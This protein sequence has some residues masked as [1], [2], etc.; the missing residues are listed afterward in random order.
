[1]PASTIR[2]CGSSLLIASWEI[3]SS[4]AYSLTDGLGAKY[5]F[6]FGSFQI[7]QDW[8]GSGLASGPYRLRYSLSQ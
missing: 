8:I 5:L 1:M 2:A 7:C 3:D 6:R 4:R